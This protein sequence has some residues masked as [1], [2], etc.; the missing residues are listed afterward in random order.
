MVDQW[1]SDIPAVGNQISADIPDIKENIHWLQDL[2]QMSI[3][4]K[5]STLASVSPGG[6]EQRATFTYSDTDTITISPAR[7]FHDGTTRQMCFWDSSITFDFGSGGSNAGSTDLAAEDWFYLYLD[8]SAI[9]TQASPELDADCFIAVTTEPSWSAAKHGW[10][11]GS[12]RCIGAFYTNGSSQLYGFAHSGDLMHYGQDIA[13]RTIGDLDATWT[14]VTM[15]APVFA[16]GVKATFVMLSSADTSQ[17]I[18]YWRTN[19]SPNNGFILG[20]SDYDFNYYIT[21]T[22]DVVTDSSQVIEV[23]FSV[24]GDHEMAVYACGYYFPNGM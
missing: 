7:Y 23:K 19:G 21:Q 15:V 11:S 6:G 20:Y 13:A 12:D 24:A 3:G 1:N 16:T 9:V 14:D 5:D 10:Y 17:A 18:G 22:T 8:D 4:W 2:M